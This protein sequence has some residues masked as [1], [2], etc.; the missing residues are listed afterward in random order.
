MAFQFAISVLFSEGR[1]KVFDYIPE[2][3]ISLKGKV[4]GKKIGKDKVR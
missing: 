1:H 3:N 4:N 2:N